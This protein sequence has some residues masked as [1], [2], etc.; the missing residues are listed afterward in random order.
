MPRKSEPSYF[1]IIPADVR[2]C[3]EL[4]PNA[5]LLYSEITALCNKEG[6]CW[7]SNRYF[8]K[9]HKVSKTSISIWIKS[10]REN[11]FIECEIESN[12]KRKIY[13]KGALRKLKG[14]YK[15]TSRGYKENLKAYK[16]SIINS[17]RNT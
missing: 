12:H 17:K 6:F 9:L 1:S 8:A 11:G 14:G 4:I 10:L 3:D 13:L 15:K 2:Y 5:K 16:S 7:A